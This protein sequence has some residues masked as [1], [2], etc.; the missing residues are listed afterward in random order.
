M[1]LGN[2]WMY[3]NN[4]RDGI[5]VGVSH[6]HLY[7]IIRSCVKVGT[8]WSRESRVLKRQ[9]VDCTI[10]EYFVTIQ[11]LSGISDED[12]ANTA[13]SQSKRDLHACKQIIHL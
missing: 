13:F 3:H 5:L 10:F 12:T 2:E 1:E 7:I 6:M 9:L 4:R 8:D 11:F